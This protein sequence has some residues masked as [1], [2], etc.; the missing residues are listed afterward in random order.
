MTEIC[1]EED[2]VRVST[3]LSVI[4]EEAIKAFDMFAWGEGQSKNKITDILAKFDK[5]C[6]PRTQ[7]IYEWYC[8]NNHKQE[9]GKGIRAYVTELRVIAK[10]CAHDEITPDKI[11][12]HHLVLGVQDEKNKRT[13]FTGKRRY[14]D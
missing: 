10:N 11:L 5:Y 12:R 1:K 6:E 3:L 14:L 7:V 4:G 2:L 13:A 8:F 9:P